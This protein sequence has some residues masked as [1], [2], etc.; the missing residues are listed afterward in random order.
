MTAWQTCSVALCATLIGPPGLGQTPGE[1]LDARSLGASGSDYSTAAVTT[2][3]QT[4]IEVAEPGD[5]EVGQGVMISECHP[6]LTK[7][8]IWGPRSK[9]T[10]E[11]KLDGKAELRGYDGTQGDWLVLFLDVPEGTRTFRWSEDLSLTWHETVPISGDWQPLRDG[12]EVKFNEHDWE[13]GYTVVFAARGQLVTTIERLEGRQVTLHDA[14]TRSSN[15]AVMRHCDDAAL[16]AAIDRAIAERRHLFVPN[17]HY[18][19]SRTLRVS[20]PDGLRIEGAHAEHTVLDISE[21]EG[22]CLQLVN[23]SEVTVRNVTMVGHSGFDQRAQCGAIAVKGASYFWGFAAK[24]CNA[25]TTS[26]TQR[27][28]LENCHGRRMASEC[29]VAA[30][31]SRGLPEAPQEQHTTSLTYLRCSA[32]DCGRNAF[33]DVNVGPENTKILQCRIVDVGG[34]S[35]EGASRFVTF[36][37]NYVRNGGTVAMGNLGVANRDETYPAVGAGQHLIADNVFESNVPYGGCMIRTAVG[38]TQV[39]IRNNLFVNF[40]S[41]AIEASGRSDP[42][43]Y[44]SSRTT[45]TGN[46]LDLT[47]VGPES[48]PRVGI[49]VSAAGTIVSDNQIYVRGECDP[50]V[51]ALRLTEPATDVTVRG[52]LIR[53]CGSGL[54]AGRGRSYVGDVV[55]DRTFGLRT[56]LLPLDERLERQGAGWRLVWLTG[57][58]RVS[59]VEAITGAA[60]PETVQVTLTEPRPSQ[61]GEAF[62]VIPP[63]ANWQVANNTF[64]DCRRPVVLDVHGGPT[65]L[66]CDNIVARGAVR[67][68]VAAIEVAGRFSLSGNHIAGF[69]GEGMTALLLKPDA[70]G[71][72]PAS[73]YVGNVFERCTSV[74]TE[75]QEGLWQAAERQGN[76]FRECAAEAAP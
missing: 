19:L 55:D 44:C 2:A 61:P 60:K 28:L 17:G 52:N 64:A 18:R 59:E 69:D 74:V 31:R 1:W 35:W 36:Q 54:L 11:Q 43:H 13:S 47:E 68:S 30:G 42:T 12:L 25:V 33:N 65:S 6:Q 48:R 67:E 10:W 58:P 29:F 49:D 50:Q 15:Q 5:F 39:I 57:E 16:Q 26:G 23:G 70:L 51:T 40:G 66:F 4:T 41:S 14:P 38:A 21:G 7:Q 27:V 63:Y 24:N 45:I 34:C 46:V 20:Q 22:A 56:R 73:R 8:V 32:I 3:G 76:V 53:N 37:G 71:G 9:L 75:T 72:L 62:E